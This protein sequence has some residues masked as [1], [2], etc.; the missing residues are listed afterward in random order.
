MAIACNRTFLPAS[1]LRLPDARQGKVLSLH[2][3]EGRVYTYKDTQ[4]LR[5]ND[6]NRS[7]PVSKKPFRANGSHTPN[8]ADPPVAAGEGGV[9]SKLGSGQQ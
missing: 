3:L 2:H 8:A 7:S 6:L 9:W 4:L 1:D 5:Y